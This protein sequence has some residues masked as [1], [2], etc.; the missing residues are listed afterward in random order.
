MGVATWL[1]PV[2]APAL[3]A[4]V[5]FWRS[6]PG[7]FDFSAVS[8]G[9]VNTG[10]PATLAVDQ[11]LA[12]GAPILQFACGEDAS[13]AKGAASFVVTRPGVLSGLGGQL[14][15]NRGGHEITKHLTLYRL[16]T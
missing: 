3:T 13:A 15:L 14:T 9:A 1:A 11:Y 2:E 12:P 8:D 5:D 6:A 4:V 10:Y 16:K 7:G